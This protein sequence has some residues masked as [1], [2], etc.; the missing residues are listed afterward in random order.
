ELPLELRKCGVEDFERP[1]AIERS[2]GIGGSRDEERLR[3][4]DGECDLAS[5]PLFRS[6]VLMEVDQVVLQRALQIP[7]QPAAFRVQP[8]EGVVLDE[9]EQQAL[10]DV[11]SAVG[12]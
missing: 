5:S 9:L 8:L 7:A 10:N 12:G 2:F 11:F 3:R 4:V 1:F 6:V